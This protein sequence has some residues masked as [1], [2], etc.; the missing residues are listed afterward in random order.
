MRRRLWVGVLLVCALILPGDTHAQTVGLMGHEP[1]W[2]EF[3]RP[4]LRVRWHMRDAG[5]NPAGFSPVTE[6]M[7]RRAYAILLPVLARVVDEPGWG[8]D[9][10]ALH[11]AAADQV[12]R[13]GRGERLLYN[14]AEAR[15]A[16]QRIEAAEAEGWRRAAAGEELEPWRVQLLDVLTNSAAASYWRWFGQAGMGEPPCRAGD[17]Y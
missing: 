14:A 5:I 16:W 6:T 8:N 7:I 2:D 3:W 4:C 13:L 10:P 15:A 12:R 17:A 1:G 11:A 9:A